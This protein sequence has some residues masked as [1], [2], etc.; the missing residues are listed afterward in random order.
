[1]LERAE[2][3]RIARKH[4]QDSQAVLITPIAHGAVLYSLGFATDPPGACEAPLAEH[5][6]DNSQ[7]IT[8]ARQAV[9]AELCG[10]V[11]D[12]RVEH[13][14]PCRCDAQ[15]TVTIAFDKTLRGQYVDPLLIERAAGQCRVSRRIDAFGETKSHQQE[16]VSAFFRGESFI[17]HKPMA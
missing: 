6:H 2:R 15:T 9:S 5:R 3:W 13:R 4:A 8:T 1:K 17:G 12:H 11:C 16:L 10:Q 14:E 7:A